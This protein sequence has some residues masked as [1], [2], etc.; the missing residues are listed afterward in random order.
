M[1]DP[2]SGAADFKR[3][4]RCHAKKLIKYCWTEDVTDVMLKNVCDLCLEYKRQFK[5]TEKPGF[6]ESFLSRKPT[7]VQKTFKMS[8]DLSKQQSRACKRTP[9]QAGKDKAEERRQHEAEL[10]GLRAQERALAPGLTHGQFAERRDAFMH[11]VEG[12]SKEDLNTKAT[13]EKFWELMYSTTDSPAMRKHFRGAKI[14]NGELVLL[15]ER[16]RLAGWKP[17]DEIPRREF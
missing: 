14:V 13:K 10:A 6:T 12:V 2:V 4:D 11:A 7:G 1:G 8:K 15:E 5:G 9:T 3:C 17:S 16:R